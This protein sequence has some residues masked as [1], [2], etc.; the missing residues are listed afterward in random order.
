MAGDTVYLAG[1]DVVFK[2]NIYIL[3]TYFH[4]R[5]LVLVQRIKKKGCDVKLLKANLK[6]MILQIN[7]SVGTK[8][9]GTRL[10]LDLSLQLDYFVI[11]PPE[12]KLGKL[13]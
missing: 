3:L 7:T 1:K 13:I 9:D 5:P 11:E 10:T 12:Y 6:F 2:V 8:K 4:L